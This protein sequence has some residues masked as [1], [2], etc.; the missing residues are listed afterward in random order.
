M[1]LVHRYACQQPPTTFRLRNLGTKADRYIVATRTN[2]P[3]HGGNVNHMT[4]W[5]LKKIIVYYLC[6]QIRVEQGKA[7]K[8]ILNSIRAQVPFSISIMLLTSAFAAGAVSASR[9]ESSGS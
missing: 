2:R 6:I 5:P 7:Q 9:S 4:S 1:D 3:V 8:P